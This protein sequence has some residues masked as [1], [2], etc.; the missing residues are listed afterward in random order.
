MDI[1]L[2]KPLVSVIMT[3]YNASAYIDEAI[4][5]ILYQTFANF[6]LLVLNDASTDST[7]KII[8]EKQLRDKRIKY[9]KN[10][11]NCGLSRTKN[12]LI[13]LAVGKYIALA[14]ADDVSQPKRFE[15][16]IDVLN[17]F[18]EISIVG[19][20][21][22]LVNNKRRVCGA[23]QY[24]EDDASIK[25]GLEE[26]SM[27]ANP[28]AMFRREVFFKINGYN[29]HLIICEDW[30]FYYR[31]SKYFNFKNIPESLLYYRFHNSNTSFTKLEYTVLYAVCFKYKLP[32]SS[33]ENTL[34][35]FVKLY[36][37]YTQSVCYNVNRFYVFSMDTLL[38]LDYPNLSTQLYKQVLEAF[39]VFFDRPSKKIFIK[40]CIVIHLKNKRFVRL[41]SLIKDYFL[42]K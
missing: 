23:W 11:N 3:A 36:P 13:P 21:I 2:D 37:M 6:E 20:T 42:I 22:S 12:Q 10:E 17:K 18:P 32:M 34:P 24:P 15:K 30:D 29:E 38:K 33:F 19:S 26:A 1:D 27:I 28:V 35:Q 16:Q 9:F 14:D 4:D 31:A 5:S 41:P 7:E 25:E 40:S 8:L 39:F